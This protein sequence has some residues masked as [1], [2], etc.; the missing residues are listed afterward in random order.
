VVEQAAAYFRDSRPQI[1]FIH[2]S[3]PDEE[4]HSVGWMSNQQ[5]TAIGHTDRCLGTLM[6]AIRATPDASR[7]LLIISADHGGSGRRHSGAIERID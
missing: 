7:T 6:N 2:F 5:L 1:E 3:D 4:G